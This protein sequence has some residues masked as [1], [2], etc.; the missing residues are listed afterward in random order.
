MLLIYSQKITPRI[1]YIFKQL[2]TEILGLEIKL[3]ADVE[4]FNDFKTAKFSYGKQPLSNELYFQSYGLLTQQGFESENIMVKKWDKTRCFFSVS[5]KSALPFDI[6]SA[7]FYLLSRYEE[8]LPHVKDDLGRFPANESLGFKHDFLQEPVVDIWAIKLKE[9]LITAFPEL[10][11]PDKRMT[12]HPVVEAK[13]PFA[14]DQLGIVRSLVGY[15]KDLYNLKLRRIAERSKVLLK[16]KPDPYDTFEWMMN[17]SKNY[18]NKLTV[19]FML[20]DSLVFEESLNTHRKKF[21]LLIKYVADYKNVGL[22][23]SFSS[24][25]KYDVL[26][27]E[28]R[29]MER[30]TNKPLM[31]TMNE[32]FIV[33]LPETYRN[34]VELEIKTDFTMVY[35]NVPGFRAGTCTPFLFYDL[36]YEIKTPLRVHPIAVTTASFKEKFASDIHKTTTGLAASVRAVN[37]TFSILFSNKDFSPTVVNGLWR[38]LFTEQI[39]GDE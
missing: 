21:I 22:I 32:H 11:F 1:T 7:A 2:C 24:V 8:Y 10:V 36:D 17:I 3:T 14:F 39:Q 15:A 34:L 25:G 35:E 20:G 19:F 33:N 9:R 12:I 18:T 37:G 5:E 31:A 16:F 26:K 27:N 30:I 23:C 38:A 28:A 6:F 29:R 4:E 13:Q